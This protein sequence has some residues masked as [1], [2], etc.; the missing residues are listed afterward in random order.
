MLFNSWAYLAFLPTVFALHW[1][2]PTRHRQAVLLLA[3]AVFYGLWDVRFLGL[4]GLSIV[5]DYIAA[6]QM[7]RA[8]HHRRRW[9]WISVGTNLGILGLFKYFDFFSQS[10]SRL[11]QQ[12]GLERLGADPLLLHVVLPV[13]VSFYTFQS[14]A[15]T[16]DVYR[17]QL[18]PTR[19]LMHFA[20]YVS[21]FPQLVAGPI[22]RAKTL[23][24]QLV[25]DRKL[26][27]VRWRALAWLLAWGS[28]WVMA[29]RSSKAARGVNLQC[30]HL[31]GT[32]MYK[33]TKRSPWSFRSGYFGGNSWSIATQEIWS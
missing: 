22:E 28:R 4:M 9:L 21:F 7:V 3:S 23:L 13:G 29:I 1:L 12:A 5:I 30:R 24:P 2:L 14:M 17:R 6:Q 10:L 25:A 15:Y 18:D 26:A 31:T 33:Q 8:D 27:D 20:L 11:L 32:P 19:N 16:I